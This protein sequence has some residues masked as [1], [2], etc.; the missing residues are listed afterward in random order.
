MLDSRNV[1]PAH[2]RKK[3]KDAN[4]IKDLKKKK[5]KGRDLQI[6]LVPDQ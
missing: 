5:G 4:K 1:Y 3:S 6:H 2:Q